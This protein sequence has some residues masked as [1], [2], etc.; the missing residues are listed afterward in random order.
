MLS[1]FNTYRQPD[2]YHIASY[3]VGSNITLELLDVSWNQIGKPGA[4]ALA[5]GLKVYFFF[6]SP[7]FK[8]AIKVIS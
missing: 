7:F 2:L 6:T 5:A 1:T 3:F 4:F 8:I